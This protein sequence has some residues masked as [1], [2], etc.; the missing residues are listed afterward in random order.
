MGQQAKTLHGLV[1]SFH[2]M[3]ESHNKWK[4]LTIEVRW[5]LPLVVGTTT[6][7]RT[8]FLPSGLTRNALFDNLRFTP[9]GAKEAG[10][11]F[12]TDIADMVGLGRVSHNY[13]GWGTSFF[14][15]DNDGKLDLFVANR[16]T[17]QDDKDPR[18]LVP[19]K[20]FLFWQKNANEGFHDVGAVSGGPFHQAHVGRELPSPITTT[21][22]T[23][24]YSS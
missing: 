23:R 3:Q 24:M 1:V 15:F 4:R 19:M 7:T 16:S 10:A 12:F 2:R 18:H 22:A 17:F 14:D 11:L 20:N 9:G 5:E 13:I 21:M 6:E 8:Y